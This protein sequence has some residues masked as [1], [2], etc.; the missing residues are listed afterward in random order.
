V[1]GER[2]TLQ[3]ILSND[4]VISKW[5]ELNMRPFLPFWKIS[6]EDPAKSRVLYTFCSRLHSVAA[7]YV[8]IVGVHMLSVHCLLN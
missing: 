5:T 1:Q 8:G 6:H 3:F 2:N 7:Y 4:S